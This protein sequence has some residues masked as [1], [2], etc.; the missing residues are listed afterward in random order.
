MKDFTEDTHVQKA[1]FGLRV[2]LEAAAK[3]KGTEL[4]FASVVAQDKTGL[5]AVMQFG[6]DCIS[7]RLAMIEATVEAARGHIAGRGRYIDEAR[8]GHH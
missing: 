3:A 4:H 8:R 6:C 5:T 1:M 7:C 2:A